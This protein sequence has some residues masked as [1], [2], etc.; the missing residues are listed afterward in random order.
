MAHWRVLW[1]FPF[2]QVTDAYTRT[3]ADVF[4]VHLDDDDD[5]DDDDDYAA[6]VVVADAI[7]LY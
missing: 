4:A 6:V 1:V 3:I 7:D 2:H 5:D